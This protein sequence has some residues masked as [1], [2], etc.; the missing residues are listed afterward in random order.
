MCVY[1]SV[2]VCVFHGEACKSAADAGRVWGG[3]GIVLSLDF[4]QICFEF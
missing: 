4:Y 3:V 1:V 2:C